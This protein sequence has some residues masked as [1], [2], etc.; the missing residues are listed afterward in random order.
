MATIR[1]LQDCVIGHRRRIA[2]EL[3]VMDEYTARRLADEQPETFEW[4][5]RPVQQFV[6]M[7]EP[8][9]VVQDDLVL[10]QPR[11]RKKVDV[12]GILEAD[13]GDESAG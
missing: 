1:L 8:A 9:P 2:G 12:I 11:K 6:D 13:D 10:R 7:V 4:V 5:D 3:V